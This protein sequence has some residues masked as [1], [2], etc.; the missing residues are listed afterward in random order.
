VSISREELTV[1]REEVTS[2]KKIYDE[3]LRGELVLDHIVRFAAIDPDTG[4]YVLGET[5]AE[6]G[7]ATHD[8]MADARLYLKQIGY[9]VAHSI[10]VSPRW[11]E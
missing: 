8:A 11:E 7:V 3:R 4:C 2:G 5:N 9:A 1:V 10:S 6:D